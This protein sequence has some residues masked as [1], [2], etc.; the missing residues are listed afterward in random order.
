M[1]FEN[2]APFLMAGMN[3]VGQEI[4]ARR[5]ERA[6]L[7]AMHLQDTMNWRYLK[8][9]LGYNTPAKQ[10]QRYLEAGLNPNL[11]YSQGS[12]GNMDQPLRAPDLQP[13]NYAAVTA[14][15]GTQIQQARLLASQADLT[16]RKVDESGV[17]QD[18]MR[19]QADLV[20]ANPYLNSAYVA[21]FVSQMESAAALKAQEKRFMVD[22][23]GRGFDR[24]Q[25]SLG[26]QRMFKELDI[27]EQR[28]RLG[29]AD[30]AIKARVFESKEFQNAILKVQVDWL[31]E[32]E[33][34]PEHWRL[35]LMSLLGKFR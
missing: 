20:K 13:A 24:E 31:R 30:Q 35:F 11:V 8:Y 2:I 14:G 28:F 26:I 18:L 7:R 25:Y 34:S 21:S 9:Q 19:A 16:E 23:Q 29:E 4:G 10:M 27:I 17:K 1:P 33:L 22:M 12:P 32:G 3:V 6:N 15:I 5:Q